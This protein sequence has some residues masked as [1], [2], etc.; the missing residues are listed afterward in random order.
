MV[1]S[2]AEYLI[3]RLI[4]NTLSEK[5]LDELL[6]GLGKDEVLNEYSPILERYFNELIEEEKPT[7]NPEWRINRAGEMTSAKPLSPARRFQKFYTD[8]RRMAAFVALLF[9]LGTAYYFVSSNQINRLQTLL[10]SAQGN[11]SKTGIITKE[12]IAPRGIRRNVQLSDGSLVKLNSDTKMSFPH[13]FNGQKRTVSLQGEAFFNVERDESKPFII[14]LEGV[15]IKVLGTS[16]NVKNYT[17]EQAVEVTVRSG[18]VSVSLESDSS[19]SIILEKNQKLIF[20]KN[21]DTFN[22]I[23]VNAEQESSWI[24]GSLQF[25]KTPLRTVE[26]TLEKWY[27]VDIIIKDESLY[28][29]SLTGTHLNESLVSMLESITYAIDA[30]Y[31]I[32]G[33]TVTIGN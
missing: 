12:E 1:R 10:E 11:Q 15:T 33:R 29:A 20:N 4:S 19:E 14:S 32:K 26:N 30:Q 31:E 5:E 28:K 25:N 7:Y 18:R 27:N 24:N 2:R 21:T 8:Y 6:E 13:T 17:D 23:D 22:I 16:F 9:S 3:N